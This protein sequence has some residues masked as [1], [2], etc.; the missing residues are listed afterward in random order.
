MY[1]FA[2]SNGSKYCYVIP[3]IQF[4]HTVK[5]F[6]VLL[7]NTNYF[8]Q[9]YLFIYIQ[10]NGCKYCYVS[11]TI[12]F[13]KSHSFADYVNVKVLFDPKIRIPSGATTPGQNGPRSNSNKEV[14]HIPQSSRNGTT[15]S[16]HFM[17]YQGYSLG[18]GI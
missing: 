10:L 2:H 12:Q 13:S 16:D 9:Y 1:S 18:G 11:L 3:I 14:F 7:F 8:I 6:Q 15:P 4:R 17:S 5:E